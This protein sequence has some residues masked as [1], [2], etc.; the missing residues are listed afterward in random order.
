MADEQ[1]KVT[2]L[3]ATLRRL[4]LSQAGDKATLLRRLYAHDSSG[5]WK[6]ITRQLRERKGSTARQ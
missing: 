2:Q 4:E 1:F 5:G 6:D 3:K